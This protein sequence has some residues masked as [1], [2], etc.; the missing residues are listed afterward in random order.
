MNFNAIARKVILGKEGE[1]SSAE[2]RKINEIPKVNT[3]KGL[4]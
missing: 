2:L 1:A 4:Q 3:Q